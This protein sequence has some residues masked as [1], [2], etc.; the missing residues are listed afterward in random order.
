[1]IYVDPAGYAE[2][3]QSAADIPAP[4]KDARYADGY[5]LYRG[6]DGKLYAVEMAGDCPNP[7][8]VL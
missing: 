7:E 1:M 2:L 8:T 3:V 6:A 4:Y 5:K